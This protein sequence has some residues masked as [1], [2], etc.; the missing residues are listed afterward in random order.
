MVNKIVILTQN[1]FI[2]N[3]T[4]SKYVLENRYDAGGIYYNYV[5]PTNVDLSNFNNSI[6]IQNKDIDLINK[7]DMF[8]SLKLNSNVMSS[9]N[10]V[11]K[12]TFLIEPNTKKISNI[13]KRDKI[14]T[15]SVN[16][17]LTFVK[18]AK[19]II[20]SSNNSLESLITIIGSDIYFI[21]SNSF[22]LYIFKPDISIVKSTAIS[23]S[24]SL[25]R[26]KTIEA[27][28]SQFKDNKTSITFYEHNDRFVVMEALHVDEKNDIDSQLQLL[29]EIK[30]T[31]IESIKQRKIDQLNTFISIPIMSTFVIDPKIYNKS[32]TIINSFIND[33]LTVGIQIQLKFEDTNVIVSQTDR[34][35][36]HI[37][38][39]IG[40]TKDKNRTFIISDTILS[41]IGAAVDAKKTTEVN[42]RSIYENIYLLSINDIYIA[43]ES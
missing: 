35:S 39:I 5:I 23:Y 22:I 42:I 11:I 38:A 24:L 10:K 6:K 37:D 25:D 29:L 32:I 19:A 15:I 36:R 7:T 34:S 14:F 2:L 18:L 28:L 8:Y 26:M 27:Y 41:I 1:D 9:N 13:Q 17:L 3:E 43:F 4:N 12:T 33:K 40:Y 20:L 30:S 21:L 16:D 31:E